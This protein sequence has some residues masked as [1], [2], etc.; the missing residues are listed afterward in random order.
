MPEISLIIPI[1]NALSDVKRLLV[2]VL[3][4]FDFNSG[5][6]ILI[7]DCSEKET[8]DYLYSFAA[9]NKNFKLLKNEKN[10][11]FVKTCNLGMRKA[12]GNI[13]VLLNSDTEIPGGFCKKIINCFKSDP[14]IGVASPIASHSVN[15]SIRMPKGYNIQ[16]MNDIIGKKHTTSY[17]L[18]PSAEGFCFCIRKEVI[19]A[20]GCLDEI[21]GKGYHEEVD[22]AYRAITNGWKNVLIDNLYVYHKRHASFG[23]EKRSQLIKQNNDIFNERWAGFREEYTQKHNL[24]NPITKIY[25]DIFPV[26]YFF[27]EVL[28][29]LAISGEKIIP[30][31]LGAAGIDCSSRELNP[32]TAKPKILIHLHLYHK[33]QLKYFL[34][35]LKNLKEECD[36]KLHVTICKD[37]KNIKK[38]ILKFS[39]SANIEFVKNI[40]YDILPFIQVLKKE[41]L[42]D[43][44][45]ILKLHGKNPDNKHKVPSI[46]YSGLNRGD[47]RQACLIDSLIRTRKVFRKNLQIISDIK[48]GIIGCKDFIFPVM[49]YLSSENRELME[50]KFTI[51]KEAVR[52]NKFI[53]DTMFMAKASV[54]NIMKKLPVREE[55]FMP[56]SE[57]NDCNAYIYIFER[58]F[59]IAANT[60]DYMIEGLFSPKAER[61]KIKFLLKNLLINLISIKKR[62]LLISH[63]LEIEGAPISLSIIA[64]ILKKKDYHIE[65]ISLEDGPLREQYEQQNI[66]VTVMNSEDTKNFVKYVKKFNLVIANT[67]VT[68]QEVRIAKIYT[69]VIWF[70]RETASIKDVYCKKIPQLY[71]TI[72]ST[73]SIYCV[74]EYAK[75]FIDRTFHKHSKILHNCCG[76]MYNG[77]KIELREK[78]SFLIAGWQQ[79][80]KDFDIAIEAFMS[81]PEEL[82]DKY[83]L[84]IIGPIYENKEQPVWSAFAEK[85][86]NSSNIIWHG[87]LTEAEKNKIFE[88]TDVL[89][90]LSGGEQCSRVVLEA[91]MFGRPVI[92]SKNADVAYMI[93]VCNGW[94]IEPESVQSLQNCIRNILNNPSVLPKMGEAARLKHLE[95][96]TV[97]IYERKLFHV[98]NSHIKKKIDGYLPWFIKKIFSAENYG[99]VK[100]IRF[101]GIRFSIIN[102]TK[103][104]E[105]QVELAGIRA[106]KTEMLKRDE[107]PSQLENKI[108]EQT[109]A[110]KY[111]LLIENSKHFNKEW[112][113]SSYPEVK[114]SKK[115]PVLH[116]LTEGSKRGYNPSADFQAD[117]YF[118]LNPDLKRDIN[119]LLH[120]ER[121]GKKQGRKYSIAKNY[122][123][124]IKKYQMERKKYPDRTKVIYSCITGGYDEIFMHDYINPE[125][126]YI[127]FTDNKELLKKDF[128]HVWKIQ[129]LR[130]TALDNTRN[131]RWHKLHPH[132]LF[133]QYTY[134]LWID[135]NINILSD[136]LQKIIRDSIAA[137]DI[138][139]SSSK[140]PLRVFLPDEVAACVKLSKDIE[141]VMEQQLKEV[142]KTG[143]PM[144]YPFFYETN[145]LFRKHFEP[146]VQ[147]TMADWWQWIEN[148]SKRDQLSFTV[149]LWKNNLHCH[150]LSDKSIREHPDVELYKH[151]V[152]KKEPPGLG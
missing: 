28:L 58:L 14:K 6:V 25:K 136:F 137:K 45:Y 64:K 125:Y 99:S 145:F 148:F 78:V 93:N 91:C 106:K 113:L 81:L 32:L 75:Q 120:Y 8:A 123:E 139:I 43:Y 100:E 152:I 132:I 31:L 10:L 130:F 96:S 104:L 134:S 44:D 116:Y 53:A 124:K 66:K 119:P 112:Y 118:W 19:T 144:D 5:E 2:S 33:N 98:V 103:Y 90:A 89:L 72:A 7:D 115:D 48:T 150:Y 84:N 94:I 131:A 50:E 12:N 63:N 18:M 29:S 101:F 86:K 143:F 74:S 133:P 60:Q 41:N 128:L 27:K 51:S 110:A 40:G 39:K 59:G 57:T 61:I 138:L 11:G 140:H 73:K 142:E 4:N 83:T 21:Y 15:Y 55:D 35:K 49:R 127:L 77:K 135:S 9:K 149:A 114:N 3:Q 108:K 147:R 111:Y 20:Q 26:K 121:T 129:P 79:N 30:M 70:I 92:I 105:E 88:E 76:D 37:D 17:P 23:I 13:L 34:K 36:F 85:I 97:S 69:P 146:S 67:V 38:K 22:F 71:E 141:S 107:L 87:K 24:E 122:D 46:K 1:Y 47:N 102:K 54:F 80:R 65:L 151:S 117:I 68:G 62:V 52:K 42:G 16:K 126:D 56:H 82:Q 95:K 109:E